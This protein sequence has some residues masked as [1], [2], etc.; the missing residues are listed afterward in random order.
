MPTKPSFTCCVIVRNGANT[1]PRLFASLAE[2]SKRGGQIC[3][4]DTGSTDGSADVVRSFGAEVTE[5]GERFMRT[6]DADLAAQIN[7]RFV[8]EGEEP[9]VKAGSR[10][11]HFA[12]AR[13]YCAGLSANDWVCWADADEAFTALD[14]DKIE[15]IIANPDL[16]Q[17]EYDFVFAHG[18]DGTSTGMAFTQ[19]KWYRRSRMYWTGAVHELV[20]PLPDAPPRRE[21]AGPNRTFVPPNIFHLEH[22]Q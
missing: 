4:T 9:I 11:F 6:I 14:L 8:V 3:I 15:E 16:D 2:F 12:D 10:L 20:T 18:P 21:G 17:L 13:N 22:W 1:L 7:E 19:S 5:V